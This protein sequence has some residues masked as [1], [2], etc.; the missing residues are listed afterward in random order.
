M[1]MVLADYPFDKI[2]KAFLFYLKTNSD[3]PAPADI[4]NVIERGGGKPPFD[5]TVYVSICKKHAD[6]RTSDE[7]QYKREYEEFILLGYN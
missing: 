7:W 3:L 5:K 1:Q 6:E 2:Q 4:V